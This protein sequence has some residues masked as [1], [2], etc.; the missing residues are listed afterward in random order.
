MVILDCPETS[1]NLHGLAWVSLCLFTAHSLRVCGDSIYFCPISPAAVQ[2]GERIPWLVSVWNF[3]V[4]GLEIF[5]EPLT[6]H[7]HA[8]GGFG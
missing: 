3:M 5:T 4:G 6:G 7:K 2:A 1:A 8:R